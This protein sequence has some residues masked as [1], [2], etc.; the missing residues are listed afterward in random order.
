MTMPYQL[1]NEPFD[2]VAPDGTTYHA[3]PQHVRDD[4][5]RVLAGIMDTRPGDDS[6]RLANTQLR[7]VWVNSKSIVYTQYIAESVLELA[8]IEMLHTTNPVEIPIRQSNILAMILAWR[9]IRPVEYDAD[10]GEP[11]PN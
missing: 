10:F 5:A 11:S 7:I 9:T 3:D 8:S 6:E 1:P 4:L 2:L